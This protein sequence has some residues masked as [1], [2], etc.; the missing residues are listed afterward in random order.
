MEVEVFTHLC[1]VVSGGNRYI[2]SG[3]SGRPS[4]ANVADPFTGTSRYV[5][6]Y[7]NGVPDS[8][9]GV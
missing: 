3:F 7:G 5:P 8:F 6:S 2:P 4:P 1:R 9:A